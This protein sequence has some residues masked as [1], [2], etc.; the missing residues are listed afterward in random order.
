MGWSFSNLT[1]CVGKH[2]TLKNV[3]QLV[4]S[5]NDIYRHVRNLCEFAH[6]LSCF[7]DNYNHWIVWKGAR[8][9]VTQVWYDINGKIWF[10]DQSKGRF[11]IEMVSLL[12]DNAQHSETW[13]RADKFTIHT[14]AII[15]TRSLFGSL[16]KSQFCSGV[17]IE[18]SRTKTAYNSILFLF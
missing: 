8:Y 13:P 17:E 7:V 5:D 18:K 10:V 16:S 12:R 3:F 15:V 9:V 1:C 4:L 2:G 6:M 11:F 14:L